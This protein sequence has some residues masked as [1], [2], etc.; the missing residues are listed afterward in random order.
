[1]YT[2]KHLKKDYKMLKWREKKTSAKTSCTRLMF[3]V[4]KE[5]G[6]GEKINQDLDFGINMKCE[7]FK[8]NFI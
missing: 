1:M 7:R 3:Y 6:V 2:I 8:I 5:G 4:N